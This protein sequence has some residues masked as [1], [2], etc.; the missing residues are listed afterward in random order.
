MHLFIS[1]GYGLFQLVD[2]PTLV[3]TY[4][5]VTT[6]YSLASSAD[7]KAL[8][9]GMTLIRAAVRDESQKVTSLI[10]SGVDVNFTDPVSALS[11]YNIHTCSHTTDPVCSLPR[12][13]IMHGSYICLLAFQKSVCPLSPLFFLSYFHLYVLSPAPLFK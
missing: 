8:L 13:V 5:Q 9:G 1:V 12:S 4:V 7:V 11:H 6:A 2:H 10:E 3:H